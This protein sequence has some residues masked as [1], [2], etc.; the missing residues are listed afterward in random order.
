MQALTD[1]RNIDY[2]PNPNML[3][4]VAPIIKNGMV[5]FPRIECK[6]MLV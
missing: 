2:L 4:T 1:K 5:F 3:Q 6:E